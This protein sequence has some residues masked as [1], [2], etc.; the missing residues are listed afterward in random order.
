MDVGQY[1]C[2]ISYTYLFV[3]NESI[4]ISTHLGNCICG[5]FLFLFIKSTLQ[6]ILKRFFNFEISQKKPGPNNQSYKSKKS[7][8]KYDVWLE[9]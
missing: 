9:W 7:I 3:H 4:K 8:L 5:T 6:I 1:P 2:S